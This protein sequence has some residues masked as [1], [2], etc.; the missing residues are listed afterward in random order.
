M[1]KVNNKNNKFKL[2]III[3]IVLIIAI[4][5]FI[6]VRNNN[7]R[8][9]LYVIDAND[10]L[11]IG[12]K[13]YLE[14]LWMVDGA[15]NYQRYNNEDFY[16]NDRKLEKNP[17]FTCKYDD[18]KKTCVGSKF[19]ENY[20]KIFASGVKMEGVYGDGLAIRWYEQ[21]ADG[22]K[23]T[24]VN[25]CG[26]GGRMSTKQKLSVVEAN[27]DKMVYK[28]TFD[29]KGEWKVSEAYYHDPCHME[30]LIKQS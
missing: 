1:G 25:T 29:E 11:S 7:E 14:F 30:Y 4:I 15:F 20:K 27:K 12:E 26:V 21:N 5:I 18:E 3:G 19:E 6:V 23:F 28:V 17:D 16:I 22:Y 8:K 13:R 2:L 24:N 9:K 10:E